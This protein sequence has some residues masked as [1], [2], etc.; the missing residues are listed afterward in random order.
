[1]YRIIARY[2]FDEDPARGHGSGEVAA[3][4]LADA[5]KES[6]EDAGAEEIEPLYLE[7]VQCPAANGEQ[8][9]KIPESPL[10][11]TRVRNK[12]AVA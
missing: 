3:A 11:C 7:T 6:D 9:Q 5:G 4:E 1:M 2:H 12:A 8:G 10:S